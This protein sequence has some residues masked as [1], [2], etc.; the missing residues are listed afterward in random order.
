MKNKLVILI[1]IAFLTTIITYTLVRNFFVK[2]F[3]SLEKNQQTILSELKRIKTEVKAEPT[4]APFSAMQ[5]LGKIKEELAR[6]KNQVEDK[7]EIL[8]L[9]TFEAT[10]TA[11]P[12]TS[13]LNFVSIADKRWQSV[14]VYQ[15]KFTS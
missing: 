8:G 14:D 15:D 4:E 9:G 5:N 6:I 2:R 7:N 12:T 1:T 10:P 13:V 3:T 11:V